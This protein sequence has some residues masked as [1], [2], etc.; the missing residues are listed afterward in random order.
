MKHFENEKNSVLELGKIMYT[1]LVGIEPNP[2]YYQ[3][4]KGSIERFMV[5]PAHLT[6]EAKALLKKM[7]ARDTKER[8]NYSN[9]IGCQ[10]FKRFLPLKYTQHNTEEC[11]DIVGQLRHKVQS[12]K[13]FNNAKDKKIERLEEKMKE[14]KNIVFNWKL[15]R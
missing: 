1:T 6:P 10:F 12:L 4:K 5:F 7:L 8:A 15:E 9:I 11:L 14:V 13:S 2:D 3:S